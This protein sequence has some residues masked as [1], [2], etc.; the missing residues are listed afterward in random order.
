MSRNLRF[1]GSD[2]ARML[3]VLLKDV[4]VLTIVGIL[5]FMIRKNFMLS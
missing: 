5:T 1:S 3:Y 2:K 4:K